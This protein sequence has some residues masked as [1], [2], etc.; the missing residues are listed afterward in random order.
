MYILPYLKLTGKNNPPKT[1]SSR[2]KN[3]HLIVL[4]VFGV[5]QFHHDV[6]RYRIPYFNPAQE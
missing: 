2:K 5:L 4:L 3:L 1:C 6:S